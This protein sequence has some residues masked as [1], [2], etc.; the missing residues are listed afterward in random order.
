MIGWLLK[1]TA[2]IGAGIVGTYYLLVKLIVKPVSVDKAPKKNKLRRRVLTKFVEPTDDQIIR[3]HFDKLL[4]VI[5]KSSNPDSIN[6]HLPIS[7]ES[8]LLE[9][10]TLLTLAC[11][12]NDVV[13]VEYLL[14][15]GADITLGPEQMV[16]RGLMGGQQDTAFTIALESGRSSSRDKILSLLLNRIQTELHKE[17]SR[18]I[19]KMNG[20]TMDTSDF[21]SKVI[22]FVD[23]YAG[24]VMMA[25]PEE[26]VK[27]YL[28]RHAA[29]PVLRHWIFLLKNKKAINEAF[30]MGGL[31]T[32]LLPDEK[33]NPAKFNSSI[34]GFFNNPIFERKLVPMIFDYLGTCTPQ[35]LPKPFIDDDSDFMYSR[36]K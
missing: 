1:I 26:H 8:F 17:A 9:G 5:D 36:L 19:A 20:Q 16:F 31:N 29:I 27:D 18:E 13:V 14:S 12:T 10:H 2:G 4:N 35:N 32:K 30:C 7:R 24:S 33:C 25:G 3:S 23:R 6:S 28:I 22:T 15:K 11:Q 34:Y 21:K